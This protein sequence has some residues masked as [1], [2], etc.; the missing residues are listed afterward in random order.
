MIIKSINIILLIG[1]IV[2]AFMLV[3][4][5]YSARLDYNNLAQLQKSADVLNKEYSR[6]Q[7]EVGTY[8][9]NL[10]L[11]DVAY[12]KLGLVAPDPKHIVEIK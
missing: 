11:Q 1:V 3:T 12:N 8:S 6:L 10:V 9:S 7:I 5:R 4:Q 2:S